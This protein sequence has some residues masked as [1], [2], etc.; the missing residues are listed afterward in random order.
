MK[1]LIETLKTM[2]NR[3]EQID[4]IWEYYKLHIIGSVA[5]TIFIVLFIVNL[6]S[7]DEDIFQI[8]VINQATLPAIEKLEEDISGQVVNDLSLYVEHIQHKGG[9]IEDNGYQLMQKMSTSLAVGQ[10]DMLIAEPQFAAQLV[11]EGIFVP[12]SEVINLEQFNEEDYQFTMLDMDEVYGISTE[13]MTYFNEDQAFKDTYIYVP[14][15]SERQG[16]IQAVLEVLMP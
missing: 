8:T 2:H 3:R 1:R 5:A 11:K 13:K 16:E 15:T 14:A 12:L 9:M 10:I 7:Q 4:Y 6:F